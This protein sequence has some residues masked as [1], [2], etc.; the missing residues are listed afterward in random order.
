MV[1]CNYLFRFQVEWN[2]YSKYNQHDN[3]HNNV[4]FETFNDHNAN[5]IDN[6]DKHFCMLSVPM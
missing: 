1:I 5:E 6:K 3:M 4:W 2:L